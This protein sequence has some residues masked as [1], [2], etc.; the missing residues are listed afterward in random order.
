LFQTSAH[1]ANGDFK[2]PREIVFVEAL[3]RTANG[4]LMRAQLRLP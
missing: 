1:R 4:K 3:P 2:R